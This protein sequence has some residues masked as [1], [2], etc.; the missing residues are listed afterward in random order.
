MFEPEILLQYDVEVVDCTP[1][2]RKLGWTAR[3]DEYELPIDF[4][5]APVAFNV[6]YADTPSEEKVKLN[7]EPITDNYFN[8]ITTNYSQQPPSVE[9]ELEAIFP[10]GSTRRSDRVDVYTA[11]EQ[12]TRVLLSQS[13]FNEYTGPG[14][15]PAF[16]YHRRTSG[17]RCE[18]APPG[19]GSYS[20]NCMK[21]MGT[22]FLGGYHA[23]IL[24]FI[25]FNGLDVKSR[26]LGRLIVTDA[27][28]NSISSSAGFTIPRP[29]D[30]IRELN[31]PMPLWLVE[32]VQIT[33]FNSRPISFI[34]PVKQADSGHPLYKVRTPKVHY[35]P[36]VV[37]YIRR[38]EDD[39]VITFRDEYDQMVRSIK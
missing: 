7:E 11:P 13:M 39:E 36:S 29:Y 10:D 19:Q 37:P 33:K 17:I 16:V 24:T 32:N 1:T 34:C 27:T 31:P 6:W 2:S 3:L 4:D 12:Y 21:C 23:P 20:A 5:P 28:Q 14:N 38:T 30:V 9:Y 22:G 18:C 8:H 26:E 35:M 15:I 25:T